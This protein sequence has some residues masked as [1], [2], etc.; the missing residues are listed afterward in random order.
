[1]RNHNQRVQVYFPVT[2]F[3]KMNKKNDSQ[4]KKTSRKP[5]NGDTQ[6]SSKNSS[7][8]SELPAENSNSDMSNNILVSQAGEMTNESEFDKLFHKWI[9]EIFIGL[10]LFAIATLCFGFLNFFKENRYLYFAVIFLLIGILSLFAFIYLKKEFPE[11]QKFKDIRNIKKLKHIKKLLKIIFLISFTVT[12]ILSFQ[13]II[14]FQRNGE[15]IKKS[16]SDLIL[17]LM[18]PIPAGNY[19]VGINKKLRDSLKEVYGILKENFLDSSTYNIQ[20]FEISRY[21]ISVKEYDQFLN[22]VKNQDQPESWDTQKMN[23]KM[24][25]TL[26][27]YD[28]AANY[29]VWLSK[30]TG[31]NYHLPDEKEWEIAAAGG[32]QGK[33][34]IYPWGDSDPNNEKL[35]F[36]KRHNGP[37][38]VTKFANSLS[39]FGAQ[40][41]AGNV[42]EWC[43]S[44][45]DCKS[46][47][48][49]KGGSWEDNKS[50][51]FRCSYRQCS[52]SKMGKNTIGFRV[53]QQ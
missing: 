25:V 26:V 27:S 42:A 30:K 49:V 16:D 10:F 38:D 51:L 22:E 18:V 3:K 24:P 6:I 31:K 15:I 37:V 44:L 8:Q 14:S 4:K 52:P 29:C 20:N 39:A 36:S 47:I 35:N 53:V 12:A 23:E 32:K 2:L 17:P 11:S 33:Q 34:R 7:Q 40:N 19:P 45:D 21:E 50:V 9:F 1:L 13:G 43:N 5:G 41:M 46:N 28:Q 48:V